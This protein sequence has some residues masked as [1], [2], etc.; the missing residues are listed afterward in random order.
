[1]V[2]LLR[3][4]SDPAEETTLSGINSPKISISY[5]LST[6]LSVMY[7]TLEHL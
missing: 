3:H 5:Y 6:L 7:A 4:N 1:M 2:T